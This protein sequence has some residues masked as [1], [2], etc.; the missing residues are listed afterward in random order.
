MMRAFSIGQHHRTRT[1]LSIGGIVVLWA[2][3][4]FFDLLYEY[5]PE[6]LDM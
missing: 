2:Q 3:D 4:R 6:G 1:S 5:L